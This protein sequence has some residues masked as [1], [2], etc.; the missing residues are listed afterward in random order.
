MWF[1]YGTWTGVTRLLRSN[2]NSW[3]FPSL[4]LLL[5]YWPI[6]LFTYW[7]MYVCGHQRATVSVLSFRNVGFGN[8]TQ[9]IRH[10]SFPC[11]AISLVL[12][13]LLKN[14]CPG[15]RQMWLFKMEYA[16]EQ[17]KE[18]YENKDTSYGRKSLQSVH[19]KG[20]TL[21]TYQGLKQLDNKNPNI[22][23]FK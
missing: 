21:G 16:S 19:L 11:Q 12:Q 20:A 13:I 10:I 9:V 17:H 3:S 1:H 18:R 5:Y 7:L 14:P 15:A 6:Y 8:G 22:S 4:S 23:V 2:S